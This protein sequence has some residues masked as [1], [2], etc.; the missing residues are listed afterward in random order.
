MSEAKT[1]SVLGLVSAQWWVRLVLSLV[2]AHWVQASL[3]VGPWG[4]GASASTCCV[5][6]VPGR[7]GEQGQVPG[8]LLAQRIDHTNTCKAAVPSTSANIPLL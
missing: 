6:L 2:P 1:Q 3:A 8:W 7:S 5:G 4:P